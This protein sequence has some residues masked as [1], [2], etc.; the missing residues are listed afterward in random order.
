M[1][2][3]RDVMMFIIDANDEQLKDPMTEVVSQMSVVTYDVKTTAIVT[4]DCK[5]RR[6]G[7]S[8]RPIKD[9]NGRFL[10]ALMALREKAPS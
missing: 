2:H 5:R 6:T 9:D 3:W 10:V 8:V 7:I 4:R 1:K